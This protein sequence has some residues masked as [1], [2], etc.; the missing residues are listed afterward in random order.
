MF[1]PPWIKYMLLRIAVTIKYL[2]FGHKLRKIKK[3]KKKKK[4]SNDPDDFF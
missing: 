2:E 3:K 4:L 1:A